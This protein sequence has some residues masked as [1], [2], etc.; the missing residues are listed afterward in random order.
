MDSAP[1]DRLLA[2]IWIPV[3]LPGFSGDDK[4]RRAQ[5]L[6]VRLGADGCYG[7]VAVAELVDFS[8]AIAEYEAAY[9]VHGRS[10]HGRVARQPAATS[11]TTASTTSTTTTTS[12]PALPGG[13]IAELADEVPGEPD[14]RWGNPST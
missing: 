8:T 7:F 4:Q 11:T 9:R 5:L 6:D 13:A 14:E 2:E 10:G 1:A 12:S 3:G